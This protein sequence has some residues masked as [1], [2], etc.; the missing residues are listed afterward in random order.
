MVLVTKHRIHILQKNDRYSSS[1]TLH[2]FSRPLGTVGHILEGNASCGY[3]SD[4]VAQ[5]TCM[6]MTLY[7][8]PLTQ[9]TLYLCA[10][11]WQEH[12]LEL[13]G[14]LVQRQ[15]ISGTGTSPF[16]QVKV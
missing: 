9:C 6:Y 13:P 12:L 5:C 4:V 10:D 14:E 2:T 3:V 7:V 8:S 15:G 11:Q 16:T 1:L